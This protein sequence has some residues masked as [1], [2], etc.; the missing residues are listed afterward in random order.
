[1]RRLA[2]HLVALISTV[3]AIAAV[4]SL[5]ATE[6]LRIWVREHSSWVY[7]GLIIAALTTFL[8]VDWAMSLHR[9]YRNLKSFTKVAC[10]HD[11]LLLHEILVLIPV[12]GDVITWLKNT[13]LVK[14]IPARRVDAITE[15]RERLSLHPVGFD[16]REIDK[17]YRALIE[18]IES[19]ESTVGRWVTYEDSN[20]T[21]LHVPLLMK[22]SEE[23][24]QKYY[25]AIG[26]IQEAAAA[27]VGAYDT[28]LQACQRN[29]INIYDPAL[30]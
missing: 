7:G 21:N 10:D 28:F 24:E 9:R 16:N 8:A 6:T 2:N 29:G 26:E 27:L 11:K 15:L 14:R 17:V 13:F 5:L 4:S 18:A 20:F 30:V 1:M 19:F 22:E 3:A 23:G 25:V 12:D